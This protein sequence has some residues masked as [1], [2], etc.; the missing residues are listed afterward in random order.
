MA[1]NGAPGQVERL[2]LRQHGV[3]SRRQLVG[4]GMTRSAIRHRLATARLV[5][6]RHDVYSLGHVA[7]TRHGQWMAAVLTCA[8]GSV[9]GH[10][11]AAC[12]W[13]IADGPTHPVHVIVP[14]TASARHGSIRVHRPVTFP[15][16]VTRR[17]GIPVTSPVQTLA[18]LARTWKADAL[19]TAMAEAERLG[20]IRGGQRDRLLA[21]PRAGH[22][23]RTDSELERMFLRLVRRARLPLPETQVAINGHRVDFAWR[24]ERL[25]VET[26]G[27]SYHR[28]GAD[29]ARDISRDRDHVAAGWR[30]LRFAYEEI[31]GGGG[32]AVVAQLRTVLGQGPQQ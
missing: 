22:R 3:V 17:H 24:S 5:E 1:T 8:A 23:L 26:D 4:L 28:T 27:L 10:A 21:G 19:E 6:V 2:A 15:L 11:S 9:L 30:V 29:Q 14:R 32:A 18:D 13:E 16:G 7:V 25:I 12:L 20:L 31:A